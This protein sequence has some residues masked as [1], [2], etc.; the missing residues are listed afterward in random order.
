MSV[1]L[2]RWGEWAEECFINDNTILRPKME[3]IRDQWWKKDDMRVTGSLETDRKHASLT[4]IT[5]EERDAETLPTKEYADQDVDI[6]L[7][8]VANRKQ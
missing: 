7:R 2:R 6:E 3:H 5:A 8:N 1:T 4:K